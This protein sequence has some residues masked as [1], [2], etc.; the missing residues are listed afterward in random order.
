MPFIKGSARR[1]SLLHHARNDEVAYLNR[2][3]RLYSAIADPAPKAVCE[4]EIYRATQTPISLELC[5]RLFGIE[6]ED[7][8]ANLI[9]DYGLTNK[10]A[11]QAYGQCLINT[12][13]TGHTYERGAQ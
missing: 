7:I 11:R 3:A 2:A 1:H 5:M 4:T 13:Q 8:Q 6:P 9:H 10:E 12:I